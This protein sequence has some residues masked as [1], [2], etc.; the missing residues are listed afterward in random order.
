MK[1]HPLSAAFP[2]MPADEIAALAQDIKA[3]GLRE[4]G[5][6]FEG[7]IL[8]GWHRYQAC[9]IAGIPF[10]HFPLPAGRDPVVFVL[11]RNLHRRHLS[12]SQRASAVVSCSEWRDRGKPKSAPGADLQTA[13][14]LAK[15]AD[16][17]TRTIER[18]KVAHKA[19]LTDAVKDGK[20]SVK[21]AAEI[22]KLPERE[23]KQAIERP[24][25]KPK[26]SKSR[27]E[28]D[29]LKA[30]IAELEEQLEQMSENLPELRAMATAA[31]AFKNDDSFKKIVALETELNATRKRRD[32]VIRE[33]AEVKRQN[34]YL[35]REIK[36]LGGIKKKAA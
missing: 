14:E 12:A 15:T 26:K 28:T 24:A 18:A 2:I 5:I 27:S 35:Q 32:D 7:K 36:K 34:Q 4:P 9:E 17:G 10:K 13:A 21:Q 23:R 29:K 33:L 22:A 6:I 30:R 19:G 8:D 1:Q 25:P 16:V 3:N 20:V 31:E 11:S